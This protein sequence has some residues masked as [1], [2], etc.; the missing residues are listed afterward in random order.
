MQQQVSQELDPALIPPGFN[1]VVAATHRI[2]DYSH[3]TPVMTCSQ[4]DARLGA[5]LFFKCENFQ[6][7]GA[8]KFRGACNTIMSLATSEIARGVATHSSGNHAGAL[9]FAA[10]L[11][12]AT[13]TVVMPSNSNE[14]K[15][16]AVRNYGG[17][18]IECEPNQQA[19]ESTVAELIQKQHCVPVVPYDDGRV[20]AGQ[21]TAALEFLE[22]T[23][24]LDCLI[25][26][27]GG[28]GL[29][30]GSTISAK[31]IKPRL[32][33]YGAEPAA[34]DDSYRSLHKGQRCPQTQPPQTIADGLRTDIGELTFP[35]IHDGVT[36]ILLAS[37]DSII[38]AMRLIW[39]RMKILVEPSSAVPL[40]ALLDNPAATA[41]K[42]V[43]IILSGGNV[44]LDH[45]PW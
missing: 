7:T 28:G 35:I 19:R 4:L 41:G 30:A 42:R 31:A 1:D 8:F 43:G 37:E 10:S 27:V 33:V 15:K 25:T 12:G 36:D 9:C 17:T 39:E 18:I 32:Q 13:A 24:D 14:V 22:Q 26:P 6:K 21:G 45:L 20:I 23:P 34:A 2:A 40:A 38:V 3:R 5:S 44:D 29:L 11:R 16:A